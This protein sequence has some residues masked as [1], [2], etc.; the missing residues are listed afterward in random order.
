MNKVGKFEKVSLYT[1][2]KAINVKNLYD[3][4]TFTY[5]QSIHNDIVLPQRSTQGSAGYDFF[6]PYDITV[7]Y[8][9]SLIIPIGIK[10]Q[11]DNG[12]F[13]ALFPRSSHGFKYGIEIA[14]T[15]GIIDSDYYN[16][17]TNEGHIL[18]KITNKDSTTQADFTLE[19]GKAFCQGIFLPF[20]ITKDE[21]TIQPTRS[22][23][24]GSTDN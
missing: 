5:H 17:K 23:G 3:I 20:G 6:L 1:F 18:V 21:N 14:N 19:K 7:R 12:W 16:N 4:D 9:E 11:I 24:I 2:D 10:A 13:L 15:V 22:G 8:G